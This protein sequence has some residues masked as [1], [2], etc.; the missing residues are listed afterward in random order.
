M[1]RVL[2]RTYAVFILISVFFVLLGILGFRY[3]AH[4]AEW[5][6]KSLNGHIFHAGSLTNAGAVLDSKGEVLVSTVDG[7]RVY[8]DSY[9][10][11]LSTLH[12]VGDKS[13]IISSS[14]QSLYRS[15]LVG[16]NRVDGLYNTINGNEPGLT[17]TIDAEVSSVAYQALNGAK[18]A[19]MVYNYK[20]GEVPCMVSSPAFDPSDPPDSTKLDN[21]SRYE[22]VYINRCSNGLF[23]PGSTMKIV[24]AISALENI[25]DIE[26]RTWTC[27]GSVEVGGDII[28]CSGKHGKV[29]FEKALNCSCNI[30][31][32]DIAI[33]LGSKKLIST[34]KE[35]GMNTNLTV[36]KIKGSKCS[37][38]LKGIKDSELGWAGVGQYKTLVTPLHMLSIVGTIANGGAYVSPQIVNS[39]STVKEYIEK[40]VPK[41]TIDPEIASKMD[42]LLRSNV[43]NYYGDR[44]F[45]NLQMTGKTGSAERGKENGYVLRHCWYVG[46]SQRDDFPYAVVVIMENL[47]S[48][49]GYSVAIPAANKVLQ[50]LFSIKGLK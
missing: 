5:A 23:T 13:G 18:G 19:I 17:L 31:F 7:K 29:N 43:K 40:A 14:V 16:Y 41:I 35:L 12:V 11:R 38:N 36:G 47:K 45:P 49:S 44:K 25:P 32:S 9:Y 39:S 27:N 24:T 6:V 3:W 26:N 10:K 15:A 37:Y 2:N 48:G 20:T 50:K 30:V 42:L 22:G 8:N 34:M 28:K 33:E 46:Y 4:G 21:D 1:K